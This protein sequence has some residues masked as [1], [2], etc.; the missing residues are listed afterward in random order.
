MSGVKASGLAIRHVELSV[1]PAS[2]RYS[3]AFERVLPAAMALPSSE[4][5]AVNVDIPSAVTL[6]LG[7]LPGILGLRD[8]AEE[9]P[10]FDLRFFEHLE[11]LV[12]ATAHAHALC[13]A[14]TSRPD[15]IDNLTARAGALRDV[16]HSDAEALA[17]RGLVSGTRLRK[18][19]TPNG[20]RN[21]AFDLLGLAVLLRESWPTIEGRTALE[22]SDLEQAELLGEELVNALGARERAPAFAAELAQQRQRV[23]TLFFRAYDEVRRA[24]CYLR[25]NEGDADW[26]APSLYSRRRKR[27][28]LRADVEHPALEAP[29]DVLSP[30]A[31]LLS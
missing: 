31:V 27:R 25:W 22:L 26:I 23:F 21:L 30:A 10:H 12:L 11:T 6:T 24:V 8:I 5:A 9:L 19:K 4:L 1:L 28:K 15:S 20:Y 14:A 2:P 29:A 13:L 3:M 7:K 17:K 18:L 16:L